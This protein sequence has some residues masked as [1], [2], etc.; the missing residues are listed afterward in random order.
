MSK[1]KEIKKI[2][3]GH[4]DGEITWCEDRQSDDDVVFIPIS[5]E[6]TK[7]DMK[8]VSKQI[9]KSL[10]T[11]DEGTLQPEQTIPISEVEEIKEKKYAEGFGDAL[12]RVNKLLMEI[13]K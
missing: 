7:E 3:L 4:H 8:G 10:G 5:E 6:F 11:S 1:L 13:R 12:K 9:Y 2:Y